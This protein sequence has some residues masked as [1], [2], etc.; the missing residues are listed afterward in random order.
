MILESDFFR[1]WC[2]TTSSIT[3]TLGWGTDASLAASSSTLS[4]LGSRN[5]DEI[6]F[7]LSGLS[8]IF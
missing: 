2:F 1:S 4:H 3:D 5:S 6:A 8:F 7:P